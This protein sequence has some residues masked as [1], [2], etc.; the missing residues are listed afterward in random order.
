MSLRIAELDNAG[1]DRWDEYVDRCAEA[2]FFHKAGWK[3]VIEDSFGRRSFFLYAERDGEICGVLPLVHFKS[4]MFGHGL[5][6]TG[7]C[8]CGGPAADDEEARD[9]LV[10]QAEDI[11]DQTGVDFMEFRQPGHGR[12]GWIG[13]QGI[14]A[15]FGREIEADEAANLKQIPRKQRAVVRKALTRD[16]S[17]QIESDVGNLYDLYAFSVRN[18]GTPVF[19]RKYFANMVKVFA[20]D[21]DI[22]T[23][24]SDGVPMS[25]VLNFYFRDKVMPHYTGGRF[26]ARRLGTNDLMYW[27]LMRHGLERGCTWFD[28]GRSKIG[29]G[30]HA[31]KKNWGFEPEPVEHA[32]KLRTG[33]EVP[34]INP[35]NP[36]YRLFIAAW[37]RLPLPLANLI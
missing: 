13:H 1:A 12:A 19:A 33:E 26:E 29:T 3:P 9:A 2:T 8:T 37:K 31:F 30:P 21:C 16:L 15:T 28:F 36:K 34:E 24:F 4:R 27:H 6:S 35:L 11:F 32:F 7:F 25:S 18:L 17:H 5:I 20:E 23:V 14:Y 22:L 10:V